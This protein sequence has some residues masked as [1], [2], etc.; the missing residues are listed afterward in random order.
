MKIRF[1]AVY[2]TISFCITGIAS[3]NDAPINFRSTG[4]QFISEDRIELRNEIIDINLY[5]YKNLNDLHYMADYD[6]NLYFK[7]VTGDT[8]TLITAFPFIA[9]RNTETIDYQVIVDQQEIPFIE[10]SLPDDSE[11]RFSKV[12]ISEI[13]FYPGKITEVR[14]LYKHTSRDFGAPV[15]VLEYIFST[16][17]Y[18]RESRTECDIILDF[19]DNMLPFLYTIQPDGFNV[20]NENRIEWHY[21]DLPEQDL[22]LEF[23][24]DRNQLISYGIKVDDE[25]EAIIDNVWEEGYDNS[26]LEDY[27][28]NPQ[29]STELR[30]YIFSLLI[31]RYRENDPEKAG[32]Y[33]KKLAES[34]AYK[35]YYLLHNL[36][37]YILKYE[38]AEAARKY[39]EAMAEQERY[40]GISIYAQLV[41]HR[42]GMRDKPLDLE[43]PEKPKYSDYNKVHEELS[44]TEWIV[45]GIILAFIL[46]VLV[47]L[48]WGIIKLSARSV[49]LLKKKF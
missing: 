48:V 6:C 7:N 24:D 16:G 44:V 18:W 29:I 35:D 30:N 9:H 2:L 49:R 38:N 33:M 34:T 27:L 21:E 26:K 39:L 25:S 11:S 19:D 23:R 10:E 17:N 32:R 42:N 45:A 15:M 31:H 40:S 4:L 28:G 41:L 20:V 3:S 47:A 46:A 5:S 37:K 1:L 8:V 14:H 36:V 12:Y 13:T 43:F 22:Y